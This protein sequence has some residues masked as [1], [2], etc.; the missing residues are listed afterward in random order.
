MSRGVRATRHRRRRAEKR[1]STQVRLPESLHAQLVDQAEKRD[2]SVNFLINRALT[3]YL[4]SAPDPLAGE[5][6]R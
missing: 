4:D 1:V 2:V 6:E 5:A 3:R